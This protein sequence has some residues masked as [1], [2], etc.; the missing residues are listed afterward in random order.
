MSVSSDST[1]DSDSQPSP[2]PGDLRNRTWVTPKVVEFPNPH[3]GEP[4][5]LV[6]STNDA[7]AALLGGD[8]G[9]NP[10]SPFASK[11][12]WEVA[13]WAKLQG[14]SSTSL[15]ELL[16][17]EEVGLSHPEGQSTGNQSFLF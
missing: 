9:S 12:D 5:Q 13:K 6:D 15:A 10:Y 3:V 17:L 14:P 8:A 11:L 2:S 7:Y 1:S 16:K 4:M